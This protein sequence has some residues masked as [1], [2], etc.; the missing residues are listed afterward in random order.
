MF[1][2]KLR[3]EIS[4]LPLKKICMNSHNKALE[5]ISNNQDKLDDDCLINLCIQVVEHF[6]DID[7]IKNNSIFKKKNF[8]D[9]NK[10]NN[11][12]KILDII[13]INQNKLSSNSLLCL[14][15]IIVYNFNS[16]IFEIISNN[17]DKLYVESLE[18]LSENTDDYEIL[19]LI[20]DNVDK[21]NIICWSNL[22][23]NL[24]HREFELKQKTIKLLLDNFEKLSDGCIKTL[25]SINDDMVLN[26]L[27]NNP[28]KLTENI[29]WN[30][31]CMNS[32]DKA[33]EIISNNISN[34]HPKCYESLCMNSNPKAFE[35]ILKNIDKLNESCWNYLYDNINEFINKEDIIKLILNNLNK[36][37]EE[38]ISKIYSDDII[39]TYDYEEMKIIRAKLINK[40]ELINIRFQKMLYYELKYGYNL[41]LDTYKN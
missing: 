23:Q 37:N 35:L 12:L 20:S 13:Y 21:L 28:H 5:I 33:L 11:I 2:Y 15:Q 19:E 29:H 26:K 38:Q 7:K 24:E 18:Y 25:Y 10:H 36:L 16:K 22:C 32:H 14:C 1:P 4:Y 6:D 34:L 30:Y 40:Q 17:V 27:F 41:V 39:F 8:I 9:N 3:E 31:L